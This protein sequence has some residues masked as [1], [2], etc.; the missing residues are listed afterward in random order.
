MT[1]N[2]LFRPARI[3]TLCLLFLAGCGQVRDTIKKEDIVIPPSLIKVTV[4]TETVKPPVKEV[5]PAGQKNGEEP[6][7]DVP[8][9]EQKL[10]PQEEKPKD[11]DVPGLPP[12]KPAPRLYAISAP[13][14]V[15]REGIITED[16][17]WQ[18]EV[19]VEGALTVAPQATLTVGPGTVVRLRSSQN[20]GAPDGMLLI[21]GRLAAKGTTESPVLFT[22]A[23]DQPA[24]GN[25]QGIVLLGSEKRNIMENCRIEWAAVGL[26]TGFSSLAM[27]EVETAHCRT[28]F[29]F[30]DSLVTMERGGASQCEVGLQ[31]Q[32]SEL[33]IRDA[34]F[35]GNRSGGKVS[36]SSLNLAECRVGRNGFDGL[37][38]RDGKVRID[39]SVFA[40]NGCGIVL[41]DCEG[42]VTNCRISDNREQGLSMENARLRVSGNEI[43]RNS[44]IGVLTGDGKAVLWGNSIAAN[45][46]YDLVNAGADEVRAFGNWWGVDTADVERRIHDR[47]D[48]PETGKVLSFP[49]LRTRPVFPEQGKFAN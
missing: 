9:V 26:E 7:G 43:N 29:L 10:L 44:G 4:P 46:L 24:A 30:R 33:D 41:V 40:E 19:L 47:T 12:V 16:T 28:G 36:A 6:K 14:L 37:T 45:G 2:E 21:Q 38:F 32:D 18:G 17:L 35:S 22:S 11:M 31:A 8:P 3:A 39:G 42:G 23:A 49:V 48:A 34:E 25:W 1:I 13:D 15:Y 27:K 5:S 20:S